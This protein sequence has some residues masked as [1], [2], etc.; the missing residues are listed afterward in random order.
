M[1][2][3]WYARKG[4][5]G[6]GVVTYYRMTMNSHLEHLRERA[7]KGVAIPKYAAAQNISQ[8]S[9]HKLMKA[10]VCSRSDCI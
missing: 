1:M 4:V 6:L 5:I 8:A 9:L 7:L 2:G 3:R 10:T